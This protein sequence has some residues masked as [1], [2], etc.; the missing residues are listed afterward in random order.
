MDVRDNLEVTMPHGSDSKYPTPIHGTRS[1]YLENS[2]DKKADRDWTEAKLQTSDIR[3]N[4]LKEDLD[5]TKNIA[6]AAKKKANLPHECLQ[7]DEILKTAALVDGWSKWW[8]GILIS[9]M[10]FLVVAGS[11]WMYQYFTLTT[12]VSTTKESVEDLKITVKK[13][14]ASQTE[15]KD[16]FHEDKAAQRLQ[17]E[18]NI[19]EIREA[20]R[21]VMREVAPNETWRKRRG[22]NNE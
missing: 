4:G 21:E 7:K 11:S 14:E 19:T 6:L 2:L 3:M 20:F 5:E 9:A 16:A 8:R 10:G 17:A 18:Q 12:E 15:L 1:S 22:D 13:I